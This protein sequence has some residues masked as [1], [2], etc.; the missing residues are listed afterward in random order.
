M[1]I[2]NWPLADQRAS[3]CLPTVSL[4][5]DGY[6]LRLVQSLKL[7]NLACLAICH[8]VSI[9]L[10]ICPWS[11][12]S[13]RR[14]RWRL[15]GPNILEAIFRHYIFL[16]RNG[17]LNDGGREATWRRLESAISTFRKSHLSLER[18]E[19]FCKFNLILQYFDQF[20]VSPDKGRP[21][22]N[23]IWLSLRGHAIQL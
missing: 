15:R 9:L 17:R 16:A 19:H 4:P 1:L 6:L 18:I 2:H 11:R 22:D 10:E 7:W 21:S 20:T 3:I 5:I 8:R 13:T 14:R 23:C 12:K